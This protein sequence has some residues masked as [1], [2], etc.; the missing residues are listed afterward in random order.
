MLKLVGCCL[1]QVCLTDLAVVLEA[2][3][4]GLV[5]CFGPSH[6]LVDPSPDSSQPCQD[7]TDDPSVDNFHETS[8]RNTIILKKFQTTG[9][10]ANSDLQSSKNGWWFFIMDFN[11]SLIFKQGGSVR[12]I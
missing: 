12:I 5:R 4:L 11:F 7:T 3:E 6:I 2:L 9:S 1:G 10:V 8:T